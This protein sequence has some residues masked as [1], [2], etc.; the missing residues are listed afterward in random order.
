MKFHEK[1]QNLRKNAG[2]TQLELA[3]KLM[4][5]RQAISKWET[6]NAIPDVENIISIC[7]LFRVSLDYLVRDT[8]VVETEEIV[9]NTTEKIVRQEHKKTRLKKIV[10]ISALIV[11]ILLV[12]WKMNLVATTVILIIWGGFC[13]ALYWSGKKLLA[14]L[15]K[16]VRKGE[17]IYQALITTNELER[18]EEIT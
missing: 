17:E 9:Q 1:L 11:I 4:V 18:K 5:L 7:D 16:Y 6:G 8:Q 13:G 10:L 3:E 2:M 12:G 15:S 14:L